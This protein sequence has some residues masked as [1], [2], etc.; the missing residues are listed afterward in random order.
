MLISRSY[1]DSE[2]EL[3]TTTRVRSQ[4]NQQINIIFISIPSPIHQNSAIILFFG[5]H[6]CFST[7]DSCN[8]KKALCFLLIVGGLYAQATPRKSLGPPFNTF[9]YSYAFPMHTN[10]RATHVPL[11]NQN[12]KTIHFNFTENS[13]TPIGQSCSR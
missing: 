7:H 8:T 9:L 10:Y 4:C 5:P 6:G 3:M 1:V 2:W 11:C 13:E 12:L